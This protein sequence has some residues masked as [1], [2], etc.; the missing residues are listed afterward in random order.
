[1][2]SKHSAVYKTIR[3]YIAVDFSIIC[4]NSEAAKTVE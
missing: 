2:Y 3:I 1:M 4:N